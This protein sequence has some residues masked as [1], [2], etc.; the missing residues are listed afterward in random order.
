[1][2]FLFQLLERLQWRF[3]NHEYR[4]THAY[5]AQRSCSFFMWTDFHFIFWL[6]ERINIQTCG[7]PNFRALRGLFQRQI[8]TTQSFTGNTVNF[9]FTDLTAALSS[10]VFI[11][12]TVWPIDSITDKNSERGRPLIWSLKV[13]YIKFVSD[14]QPF[15]DGHTMLRIS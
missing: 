2:K 1:M 3:K 11:C 10:L 7:W 8:L 13:W 5:N 12:C 6:H 4:N 9:Y 15:P 14:K